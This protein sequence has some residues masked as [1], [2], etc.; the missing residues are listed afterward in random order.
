MWNLGFWLL[1]DVFVFQEEEL[2]R[3]KRQERLEM[4]RNNVQLKYAMKRKVRDLAEWH[5]G[6]L[7]LQKCT[8]N[9]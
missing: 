6:E 4:I 1:L 7:R 5:F 3:K 2:K 8:Q 9:L